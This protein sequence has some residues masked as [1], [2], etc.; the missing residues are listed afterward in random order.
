MTKKGKITARTGLETEAWAH[1]RICVGSEQPTGL[2]AL[3]EAALLWAAAASQLGSGS[4]YPHFLMGNLRALTNLVLSKPS[5]VLKPSIRKEEQNS[6]CSLV[7]SSCTELQG[8]TWRLKDDRSNN[9]LYL[10][11]HH[12]ALKRK[13][14]LLLAV[15]F[16]YYFEGRRLKA[17][18]LTYFSAFITRKA[19]YLKK[20]KNVGEGGKTEFTL[21]HC[22]H[23]DSQ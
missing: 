17:S 19:L 2:D 3:V 8:A 15:V 10:Q 1:E 4:L 20:K 7:L 13:C 23:P 22:S 21:H 6:K 14:Y 5:A 12:S 9:W 18:V 11:V 16:G